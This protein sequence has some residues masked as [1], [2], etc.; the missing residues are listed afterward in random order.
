MSA[1]LRN[2]LLKAQQELSAVKA[3][4]GS[5]IERVQQAALATLND[6]ELRQLTARNRRRFPC[7]STIRH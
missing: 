5:Q 3:S 1:Q 7:L 2:Q 4:V 6:E